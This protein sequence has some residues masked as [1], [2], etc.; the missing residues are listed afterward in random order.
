MLQQTRVDTVIDYY[1]RWMRTF[2][3]LVALAVAPLS[4]VLKSWEGLGYYA[5]ARN[6][7]RTARLL[8]DERA[9]RFPRNYAGLCALPGIGPYTAAAIG[10]LSMGLDLAVVDGNVARVLSRLHAW[11]EEIDS[12]RSKQRLQKW[13]D[14]QLP[15]GRA[16]EMNEAMMELGALVC[17]PRSPACARCP[18]RN[19]CRGYRTG[20]PERFPVKKARAAVPHK[21]VGAGLV[22]NRRNEILVARRRPDSML[23]GLWEF[24]GGSREPGETIEQCIARELCEELGIHVRVG[25]HFHTVYHAFSHFTMDLRVHWARISQGRPRAIDCT[26]Y[27]WVPVAG[28][29]RLALPGADRKILHQLQDA[30]VPRF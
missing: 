29:G 6:A 16:G 14:G 19:V 9:G 23:G 10:S 3:S 27:R 17:T 12:E 26:E 13:A 30:E 24:P 4:D 21:E 18:L 20:D 2:P 22:V 11:D 8:V 7:H 1:R 28:I 15:P 5:R 25:P